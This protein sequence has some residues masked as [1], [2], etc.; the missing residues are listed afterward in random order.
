MI[1]ESMSIESESN[2]NQKT[3]NNLKNKRKIQK[4]KN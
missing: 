2:Q 1:E 3:F 4:L